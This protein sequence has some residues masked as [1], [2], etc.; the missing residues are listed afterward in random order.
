MDERAMQQASA[1]LRVGFEVAFIVFVIVTAPVAAFLTPRAELERVTPV[2]AALMVAIVAWTAYDLVRVVRAQRA[3]SAQTPAPPVRLDAIWDHADDTAAALSPPPLVGV[4]AFG[5]SIEGAQLLD[6]LTGRTRAVELGERRGDVADA[7]EMAMSACGLARCPRLYWA[8]GAGLNAAVAGTPESAAIV[9]GE[10][11][12][13]TL[14]AEALLGVLAD[15]LVRL[16]PGTVRGLHSWDPPGI[17]D[18]DHR[19][20]PEIAVSVY[21]AADAQAVLALRDTA[22]LFSALRA[23]AAA[24]PYFPGLTPDQAHLL[25]TWPSRFA[26]LAGG[27]SAAAEGDPVTLFAAGDGERLE[28]ARLRRLTRALTQETEASAHG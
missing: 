26:P 14:G 25:W 10:E 18:N 3:A 20:T 28:M 13:A 16:E 11:L 23:T 7:L 17:L 6:G 21:A 15:L 4:R 12:L 9:L 19:M 27:D 2:F 22:P 5:G 8:P 1:W 24:D